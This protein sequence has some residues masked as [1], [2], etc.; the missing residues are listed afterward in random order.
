MTTYKVNLQKQLNG[1]AFV[2][3]ST[4]LE[5]TDKKVWWDKINQYRKKHFIDILETT[6][7]V[8]V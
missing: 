1:T 7:T 6:A 5:T 3:V 2:I 8:N 4:V